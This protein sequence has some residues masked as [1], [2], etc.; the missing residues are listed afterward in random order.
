MDS[1]LE[2]IENQLLDMNQEHK[3]Y[4]K[5]DMLA[6]VNMVFDDLY[7]ISNEGRKQEVEKERS[8]FINWIEGDF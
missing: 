2:C 5:E 6:F 7:S 4:S 3:D 8:E 1:I